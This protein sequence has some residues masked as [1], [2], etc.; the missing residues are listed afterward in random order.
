MRRLHEDLGKRRR[1]VDVETQEGSIE[2]Q[3]PEHVRYDET[4]GGFLVESE[5]RLPVRLEVED[6]HV[7]TQGAW[8][9]YFGLEDVILARGDL[10]E[11]F[12]LA[13]CVDSA[14][15]VEPKVNQAA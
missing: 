6:A 8:T 3:E 5:G 2:E 13:L 11:E 4:L 10:V 12:V 14:F 9:E 7:V 15:F 1:L